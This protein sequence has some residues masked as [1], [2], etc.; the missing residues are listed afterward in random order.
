[1]TAISSSLRAQASGSAAPAG[2]FE[3]AASEALHALREA[4]AAAVAAAAR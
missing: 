3:S 2:T 4:T 1:M